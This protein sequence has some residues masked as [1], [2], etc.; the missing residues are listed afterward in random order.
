MKSIKGSGAFGLDATNMCLLPSVKIPAKFKVPKFE[1]YKGVSCPK[2]HIRSFSRKMAAHS[3]DEKMLMHF[4]LENLSGASLEWYMQFKHTCIQTWRELAETFLK[5]YQY[6]SGMAYNR[7]HLQSLI[8][9]PDE[10]FKGYGQ[11]WRHLVVRVQPPLLERELVDMFMST[12]YGP[13]L[14]R[15]VGNASSI[16][17]DLVIAGE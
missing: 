16:F 15:V 14:D 7:A 9:R 3:D 11:R 2:T 8:Q 1:K 6:Y 13:Y 4:F 5:H 12:L 17:S 10:L